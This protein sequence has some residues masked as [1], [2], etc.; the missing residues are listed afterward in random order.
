MDEKAKRK[1][2]KVNTQQQAWG[3]RVALAYPWVN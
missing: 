1:D 2:A 3:Q